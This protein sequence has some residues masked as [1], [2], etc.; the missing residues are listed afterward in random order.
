ML[1]L[2][3]WLRHS[4]LWSSNECGKK[5]YDK[6]RNEIR[7]ILHWSAG[8]LPQE[9]V[10]SL[11]QTH[12]PLLRPQQAILKF[13]GLCEKAVVEGYGVKGLSARNTGLNSY[14]RMIEKVSRERNCPL[15]TLSV[16]RR[17]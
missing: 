10:A 6:R 7:N 8:C 13:V 3:S 1:Q 17:P 4:L 15:Y 5:G 9:Q 2:A 16:E 11:A 12:S 14:C